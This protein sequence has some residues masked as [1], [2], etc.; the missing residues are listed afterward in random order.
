MPTS[1]T[2][3]GNRNYIK[4]YLILHIVFD[5]SIKIPQKS[6]PVNPEEGLLFIVK[7]ELNSETPELNMVI[8]RPQISIFGLP[9]HRQNLII[10]PEYLMILVR[11]HPGGLFKL[12][13]I[14]MNELI[15]NYV[16]AE[17]VFGQKIKLVNEQLAGAKSYQFM[18]DVLNTFF[19]LKL[20]KIEKN[21]HPLDKIGKLILSNPKNFKLETFAGEACLSHRQF[22]KR[23]IQQIGIT[24]KY[25]ARI[26][27]FYTAYELK[28]LNP[29]MTWFSIAI[30]SGYNDYQHLAK[31]FKEFS[32]VLPNTFIQECLNNPERVLNISNNFIGA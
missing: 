8:K 23:F 3:S 16:D 12:L 1:L 4:K 19:S 5:N 17:L 31:D 11:F 15:H 13:G 28:E 20:R 29:N 30:K 21:E 7:G 14:P 25:F 6:Y 22:E 24:P 2:I 18:L 10:S 32:G 9:S 27:R 26:C